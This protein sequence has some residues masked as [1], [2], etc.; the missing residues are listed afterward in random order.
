MGIAGEELTY[1]I[2][3]SNNGPSDARNVVV[4]DNLP[5]SIQNPEYSTDEWR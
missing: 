4:S 5:S 3:V 2:T 1:T